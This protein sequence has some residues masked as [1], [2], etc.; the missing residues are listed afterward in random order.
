MLRDYP[1]G[2][3]L[4]WET[5]DPPELK[6]NYTYDYHKGTVKLILRWAAA[7]YHFIF[8]NKRRNTSVLY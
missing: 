7:N 6:G 1:T 8:I 3:M 4:T 5:N 2:T